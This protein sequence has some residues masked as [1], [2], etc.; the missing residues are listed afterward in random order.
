[1]ILA[2]FFYV[3]RFIFYKQVMQKYSIQKNDRKS[4]TMYID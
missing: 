1:M 2:I 4:G 3:A